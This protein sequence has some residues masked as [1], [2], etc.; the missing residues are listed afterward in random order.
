M[1]PKPHITNIQNDASV[2]YFVP[3]SS[4]YG[5]NGFVPTIQRHYTKILGA[6][7]KLQSM[8]VFGTTVK[9]DSN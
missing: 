2:L 9:R 1:R 4:D 5:V 8:I 7:P 3:F 6:G